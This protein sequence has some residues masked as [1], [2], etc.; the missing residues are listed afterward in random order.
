MRDSY[1]KAPYFKPLGYPAGVYRVGPL[2]R[3]NVAEALRHAGGRSP[4]SPNS[5]SA[6]APC[7]HSSFH[8]H[9]AR[10]IELLHGLEK[11]ELL[12]SRSRHP[13][14]ARARHAPA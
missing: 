9:Y 10:L 4:N 6:A 1:L 14:H 8:Y 7:V 11:I 3:L 5:A 13:R 12:L 2:A